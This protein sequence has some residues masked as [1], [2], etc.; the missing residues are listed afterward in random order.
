MIL[1]VPVVVMWPEMYDSGLGL[2]WFAR[3]GLAGSGLGL[4]L[5]G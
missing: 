5:E 1:V 2:E 4:G 3:L